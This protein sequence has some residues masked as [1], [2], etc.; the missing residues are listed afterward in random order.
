MVRERPEV[1]PGFRSMAEGKYVIFYR[2]GDSGI[3]ILRIPHGRMD[4]ER[5]L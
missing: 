5:C 3:G 4:I 2:V 1:K